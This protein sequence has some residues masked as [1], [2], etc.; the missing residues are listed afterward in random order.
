MIPTGYLLKWHSGRKRR[1]PEYPLFPSVQPIHNGLQANLELFVCSEVE[2]V[3]FQVLLDQSEA[4]VLARWA[5]CELRDPREQLRFVFRQAARL[6]GLMTVTG[7]PPKNESAPA[8]EPEAKD[9]IT[10]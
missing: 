3:R 8:G 9:V 1:K 10:C 4:E 2:M 6:H 7:E 5:A